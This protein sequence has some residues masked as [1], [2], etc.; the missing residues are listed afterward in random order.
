[1]DVGCC[2]LDWICDWKALGRLPRLCM[3]AWCERLGLEQPA[4]AF[5]LR[6]EGR[7]S[8][9]LLPLLLLWRQ[10]VQ[11]AAQLEKRAEKA[12]SNLITAMRA[13][14]AAE[15]AAEQR[16]RAAEEAATRAAEEAAAPVVVAHAGLGGSAR[17]S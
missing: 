11:R 8:R 3:H 2:R 17:G 12:E 4:F 7:S 14:D 10:A 15:A 9:N 1:M 16:A 13:V 5:V 6:Q